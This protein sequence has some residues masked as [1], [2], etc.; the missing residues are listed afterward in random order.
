ML[1][2]KSKLTPK[3][4]ELVRKAKKFFSKN[5]VTRTELVT[6]MKSLGLNSSPG[7]ITK[8]L[9]FKLKDKA[10]KIVR[11]KYNLPAVGSVP[12]AK[13]AEAK[14]PPRTLSMSKD[15]IRKRA[16]AA[17]KKAAATE[18]LAPQTMTADQVPEVSE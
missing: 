12:K 9:A 7:F 16:G 8:N 10:G 17:A 18:T 6:F 13:T 1:L 2:N 14:N 3:Q 4:V 11:G 15:A 5:V